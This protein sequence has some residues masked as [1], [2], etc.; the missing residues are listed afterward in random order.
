MPFPSQPDKASGSEPHRLKTGT[1]Q[2]EKERISSHEK[3]DFSS[4]LLF[5][6]V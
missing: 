5:V 2:A 4:S 1:I 3:S 6:Q